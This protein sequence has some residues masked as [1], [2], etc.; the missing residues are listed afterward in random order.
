MK[1]VHKHLDEHEAGEAVPEDTKERLSV[2]K[3]KTEW[4]RRAIDR[5]QLLPP[6]DTSI[7]D[8]AWKDYYEE[9]LALEELNK[10]ETPEANRLLASQ[11]FDK[12]SI[13]L[14]RQARKDIARVLRGAALW[15]GAREGY[16]RSASSGLYFTSLS[17]VS[18]ILPPGSRVEGPELSVRVK[19][20]LYSP[21][22]LG[23]SL[24]LYYNH[25]IMRPQ[26][27]SFRNLST[28]LARD[29]SIQ[30][31]DTRNP[32]LSGVVR[33]TGYGY[34]EERLPGTS[35]I[36][37]VIDERVSHI[38]QAALHELEKALFGTSRWL[39]P[40]KILQLVI[41]AA[42]AGEHWQ[43]SWS[44][45]SLNEVPPKLPKRDGE[46]DEGEYREEDQR[47]LEEG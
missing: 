29:R 3:P 15:D 8:S 24:D 39:S 12:K 13:E 30:D 11:V 7:D 27:A 36:L 46:T 47:Q 4:A 20:R 9:R 22:G 16:P 23:T 43:E 21:L 41:T 45:S 32:A 28:L 37:Q 1:D 18:G 35:E 42:L 19:T 40:R 33:A 38:D 17:S 44:F 34:V 14:L 6:Y 25:H 2:E 31:C 10:I 5:W 26:S